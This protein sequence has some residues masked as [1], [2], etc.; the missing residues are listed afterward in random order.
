MYVVTGTGAVH[1]LDAASGRP[2]W[3]WDPGAV[4]W[5]H[6]VNRP[7]FVHRGLSLWTGDG[8][9]RLLVPVR[10]RLFALDPRTGLPDP[11]FGDQGSV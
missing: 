8:A 5:G 1:A 2:L 7:G 3:A 9:R 4:T 6:G 11:A 10:W